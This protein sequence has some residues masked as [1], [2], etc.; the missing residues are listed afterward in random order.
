MIMNID[1]EVIFWSW[2]LLKVTFAPLST[3]IY[4]YKINGKLQ[5]NPPIIHGYIL[6]QFL[7]ISKNSHSM[8][9][10]SI[11]NF[12]FLQGVERGGKGDLA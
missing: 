5:I 4:I 1:F 6:N 3:N 12:T 10:N 2:N 8:L 7:K 11:Q 9:L